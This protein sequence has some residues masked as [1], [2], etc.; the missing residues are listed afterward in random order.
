[1]LC[2]K[3]FGTWVGKVFIIY[4]TMIKQELHVI[5]KQNYMQG[6]S[7]FWI[8]TNTFKV[9]IVIPILKD[10][11]LDGSLFVKLLIMRARFWILDVQM[12]FCY[13]V[14]GSGVVTN[15]FHMELILS[16]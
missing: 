15:S 4:W 9:A 5:A 6:K 2:Y 11:L 14:Y 3:I 13:T 1:M 10:G 7:I 12:V 16:R 8:L